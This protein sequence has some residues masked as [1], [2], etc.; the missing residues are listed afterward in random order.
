[1]IILRKDNVIRMTADEKKVAD[2][3]SKGYEVCGVDH[4]DRDAEETGKPLE[5]MT[6]KELKA[7]AKARGMH[8]CDSLKKDEILKILT[9]MS[10]EETEA[11]EAD[12]SD[13]ATGEA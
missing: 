4:A 5:K 2:L 13:D 6:A 7:Y 3:K 10:D 1:M 8:G 9:G 11:G 12:G